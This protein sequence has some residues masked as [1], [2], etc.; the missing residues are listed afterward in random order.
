MGTDGRTRH[1]APKA[2]TI[3][4]SLTDLCDIILFTHR[5]SSLS[6]SPMLECPP[7]TPAPLQ[8]VSDPVSQWTLTETILMDPQNTTVID[9][10]YGR[11]NMAS[12]IAI[13]RTSVRGRVSWLTYKARIF[14]IIKLLTNY[15]AKPASFRE[16]QRHTGAVIFGEVPLLYFNRCSTVSGFVDIAVNAG[17]ISNVV[18]YFLS[19]EGYKIWD[20][21]KWV[22]ETDW[23]HKEVRCFHHSRSTT[24]IPRL[25]SNSGN[26]ERSMPIDS[27]TMPQANRGRLVLFERISPSG[28]IHVI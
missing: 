11:L 4:T 15:F 16:L 23:I 22:E 14:N 25:E 2:A 8:V 10:I 6:S 19:I 21:E 9:N 7:D 5:P 1:P 20:G 28:S 24:R 26:D 18:H 12:I 17:Y 13:S 27:Y 3:P